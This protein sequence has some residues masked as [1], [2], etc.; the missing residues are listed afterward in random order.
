M[1]EAAEQILLDLGLPKCVY[2]VTANWR[3]LKLLSPLLKNC[4][5][6]AAPEDRG[7]FQ[8]GGVPVCKF[9]SGRVSQR[10][11]E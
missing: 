10:Q 4:A 5:A 1:I 11:Y 3:A 8:E 7:S 6:A 9:R 2:A